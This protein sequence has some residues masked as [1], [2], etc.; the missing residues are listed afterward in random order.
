MVQFGVVFILSFVLAKDRL[1]ISK[2]D[3]EM[4]VMHSF[5][6]LRFQALRLVQVVWDLVLWTGQA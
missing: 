1:A 4:A 2:A 6:Y 5:F 3:Q